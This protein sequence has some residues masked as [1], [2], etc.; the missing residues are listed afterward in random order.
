MN[1]SWIEWLVS[2][3]DVKSILSSWKNS[4]VGL[5]FDGIFHGLVHDLKS[6]ESTDSNFFKKIFLCDRSIMTFVSGS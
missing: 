1:I 4:S 6:T 2:G 3:I 5:L